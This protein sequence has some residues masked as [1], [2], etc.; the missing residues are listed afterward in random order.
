MKKIALTWWWTWWH[1]I[2][3]LSLHNYLKNK[4]NYE[5]IW[6]WDEEW[7]E[8]RVAWENNIK[9][10]HIP[11]WKIRRYFDLR[12]FYE[13]LKNLT[14]VFFWI[15]YLLVNKVDIIF[16]KWWFVSLPICIA[17]FILRKDIYIH[18]SD[19]VSGLANRLISKMATKVF[20]SFENPIIDSEKHILS[21]QILNPELLNKV[22][23]NEELEENE[24]LEVL[25]IAWSQWSTRILQNLKTILNNLIDVNFTIILWEKNLHFRKEF[26]WYNN[27][28][29][30]D[31]ISQ[32]DLWVIYKKTDIAITRGGATTLWELYFF[33][34]HSIIIPLPESASNHQEEN[35]IY[36]KNNFWSDILKESDKLNL[37]I[38]RLVNKYKDLRK[39]ELNLKHF[40]YALQKIKEV[41]K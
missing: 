19:T 14:W 35:A 12:N 13:P 29:L 18:E 4:D 20:Y 17:W 41:I 5:F 28:K 24:K 39:K 25:V 38:F 11:S 16:S 21:W 8:A 27:V 3:L 34:I 1:I 10:E 26:E 36:F 32:E 9:F 22:N 30:Y 6:F 23:K 15:Y 7:L 31:F 2:P 37:D 33:G 40:F